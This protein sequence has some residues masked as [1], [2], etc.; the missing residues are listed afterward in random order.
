M[1]QRIAHLHLTLALSIVLS[2]ALAQNIPNQIS[3]IPTRDNKGTVLIQVDWVK[4]AI[5]DGQKV[6]V[7]D[8]DSGSGFVMDREGQILTVAHHFPELHENETMLIHGETEKL[9]GIDDRQRFSLKIKFIDR[10]ADVAIL[11][12]TTPTKLTPIPLMW[13][14]HPKE[15]DEILIRGFP[16]GGELESMNGIIRKTPDDFLVKSSA[17]LRAGY[18]GA[19]VYNMDGQVIGVVQRGEPVADIPDKKVMGL[20]EFFLLSHVKNK[21]PQ[22]LISSLLNQE[23]SPTVTSPK[24]Q[25]RFT[26][27]I[28][29]MKDDHPDPISP[30]KREYGTGIIKAQPGYKIVS[31]EVVNYSANGLSNAHAIIPEDKSSIDYK[32]TLESGPVW[33]RYRGWFKAELITIQEATK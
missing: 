10:V 8:S 22:Q 23:A 11:V 9:N 15:G 27:T 12:P 19:A 17:L 5:E 24:G 1:K 2:N 30:H 18:S 3:S 21:L 29:V 14:S 33:D 26:Y 16:L 25:A 7:S 6:S 4:E 32:Y 31:Y 28:D 20:G 13:D